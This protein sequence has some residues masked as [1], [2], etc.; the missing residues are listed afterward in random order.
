MFENVYTHGLLEVAKNK[1][2]FES[3][4][5]KRFFYCAP[6]F[7][8]NT[9]NSAIC[10]SLSLLLIVLIALDVSLRSEKSV[11]AHVKSKLYSDDARQT[12]T[13]ISDSPSPLQSPTL[14]NTGQTNLPRP[15][16]AGTN[17]A[18]ATFTGTVEGDFCYAN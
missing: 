1:F 6:N 9:Q 10:A 16:P 7:R 2:K 8:K 12:S 4:I 11:K 5:I 15:T 14:I 17:R 13:P 3:A 18:R